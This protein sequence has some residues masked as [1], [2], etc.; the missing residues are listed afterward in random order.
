LDNV[1]HGGA[2]C[3]V[4]TTFVPCSQGNTCVEPHPACSATLAESECLTPN[5]LN[6]PTIATTVTTSGVT[7][8]CV[9]GTNAGAM[10]T[11]QSTCTG[12]GVCSAFVPFLG[13]I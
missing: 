6:N 5:L 13:Q 9:G 3:S 2:S 10:C 7:N 11:T 8:Q 4:A 1:H 12:G